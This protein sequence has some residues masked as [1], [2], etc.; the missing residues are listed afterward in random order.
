MSMDDVTVTVAEAARFFGVHLNT[1][2]RWIDKAGL[3]P[4]GVRLVPHQGKPPHLY[5]L[6][7][8]ARLEQQA[9]RAPVQGRPR[10]Q[11]PM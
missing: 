11:R 10:K 5:R 6:G 1:V 8:L 2:W 3:E 9:R 4:V 7:D